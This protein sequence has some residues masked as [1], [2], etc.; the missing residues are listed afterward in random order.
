MTTS[1]T[2]ASVPFDRIAER[3]EA[4]GGGLDRG[5]RFATAMEPHLPAASTLLEI[6]VGT[7]AIAQP[8]AHA[9]HTVVGIDLSRPMLD[10]AATRLPG[11]LLR[12][13]AA[14][15]PIADRSVDAVVAVWAVHVVGDFDALVDEVRRVLRPDGVWLVVSP[16]PDVDP[17]DLTDI[18]HRYA[19]VLER[20]W[21]RAHLLAPRLSGAGFDLVDDVVTDEHH[22]SESPEAR[23]TSIER[24]EWSTLWDLDAATWAELVQP[25]LDDLRALPE[26][27]RPRDCVHR[28]H[29]SVYRSST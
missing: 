24:R 12:G 25:V 15:L 2:G 21:D 10:I 16:T 26:P 6:C 3:Y 28:H 23:A 4:T 14:V 13:D 8:L 29:L 27:D 5:R 11:M 18:A 19:K 17:N 7:G 22:F 9:G 1:A 20:G